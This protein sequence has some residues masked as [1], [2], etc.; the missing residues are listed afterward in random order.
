[1]VLLGLS[2]TT[3]LAAG[4]ATAG[5]TS[6]SSA[7]TLL[8]A[9]RQGS[10]ADIPWSQVGPGW[11]LSGWVPT[12]PKTSGAASPSSPTTLYLIDP[13]GGRYAI[14]APAVTA[15]SD[16]VAWSGDGRRALFETQTSSVTSSLVTVV[17]LQ[18]GTSTRFTI[19]SDGPRSIGFTAPDGLAVIA[20]SQVQSTRTIPMERF[21]LSGALAYTYPTSFPHAGPIE[22]GALYTAD[23]TE[24]VLG[25]S[26][27][28]EV[29]TNGGQPVRYLPVNTRAGTCQPVR[30]WAAGV[31]LASCTPPGNGIALLWLVPTDGRPPTQLTVTPE[32]GSGDLG[33]VD[34][35]SLPGGDYLQDLG[36]CGYIYLAKLDAAGRTTPIRVPGTAAGKS[37][38]VLGAYR[39]RL[40]LTASL[41]CSP[42]SSSLMWFDPGTNVVTPLLGP[43]VNG[44]SAGPALLFGQT[45]Y[46]PEF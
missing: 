30:W 6:G 1:M 29:V 27:G 32:R 39:D 41:S 23:G 37:V 12:A 22:G 46:F 45:P 38:Y 7:T 13:L 19:A 8:A 35:W 44:G 10:A 31:V 43:P 25:T 21:D 15:G 33:D 28:M 18:D 42:G 34:A 4:T 14:A 9:G 26:R 2:T 40:A 16:L 20:G 5:A 3:V 24:L 11:L 17:Q 36:P